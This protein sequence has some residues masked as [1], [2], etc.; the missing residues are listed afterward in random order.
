MHSALAPARLVLNNARARAAPS[1]EQLLGYRRTRQPP[2]RRAASP[3]RAAAPQDSD[4]HTGRP[5]KT[6]R[7]SRTQSRFGFDPP[8]LDIDQPGDNGMSL[9]TADRLL[10]HHMS[11]PLE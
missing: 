10:R 11:D 8:A 6:S 1:P 3:A 5:I 9:A 7:K 4:R 2:Q